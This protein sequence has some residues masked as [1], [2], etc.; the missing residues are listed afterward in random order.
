[1][2]FIQTFPAVDGLV[3]LLNIP[4]MIVIDLEPVYPMIRD[5]IAK[6]LNQIPGVTF[7]YFRPLVQ[8]YALS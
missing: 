8:P 7:Q 5:F 2:A 1:M 4:K 6:T 3:V